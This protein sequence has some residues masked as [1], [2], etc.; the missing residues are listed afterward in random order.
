MSEPRLIT[1]EADGHVYEAVVDETPRVPVSDAFAREVD[2]VK[3]GIYVPFGRITAV[4]NVGFI[5][6]PVA[7]RSGEDPTLA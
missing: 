6:H 7:I 3:Y 5:A 4:P 1:F 2:G